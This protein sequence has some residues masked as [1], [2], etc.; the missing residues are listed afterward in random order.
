MKPGRTQCRKTPAG[1]SAG[2]P[3]DAVTRDGHFRVPLARKLSG[4][5]AGG[6]NLRRRLR[7]RILVLPSRPGDTRRDQS[8][9]AT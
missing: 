3:A 6:R 8:S 2:L 5:R 7:V 1:G 4:P 9:A